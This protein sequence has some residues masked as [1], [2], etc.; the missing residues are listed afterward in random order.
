MTLKINGKK[1]KFSIKKMW[2]CIE[3]ITN[4]AL[5]RELKV[6]VQEKRETKNFFFLN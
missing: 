3:K 6:G 5:I 1:M 4:S 2:S